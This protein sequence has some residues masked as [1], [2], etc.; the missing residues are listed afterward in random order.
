MGALMR[1]LDTVGY[2]R[3]MLGHGRAALLRPLLFLRRNKQCLTLPKGR[4]RSR[5]R[6]Q[7][8]KVRGAACSFL[9]RPKEP[10][11]VANTRRRRLTISARME[12]D[13]A[14]K[15]ARG[16]RIPCRSQVFWG[17]PKLR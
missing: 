15:G 1:A 3:A 13:L 17:V 8:P 4:A 11:L 9:P 12:C 14:S 7:G 16:G 6:P 2:P 10:L 5:P